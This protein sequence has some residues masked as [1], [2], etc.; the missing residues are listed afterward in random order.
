[1]VYVTWLYTEFYY[2][3]TLLTWYIDCDRHL[4]S[5]FVIDC[6]T[7]V[8]LCLHI[9]SLLF[10]III[11][12]HLLTHYMHVHFPIIFTH[13]LGRFLTILDLHVQILD[14][15]FLWSGFIETGHFARSM[16]FSLLDYRYSCSF[17]HVIPWFLLY[18]IQSPFHILIHMLSL[19]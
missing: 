13:S 9:I 3:L 17:I 19:C 18:H 5:D 14:V 6:L 12:F 2:W 10:Q 1:M 16:S 7:I 11:S 15:L 8:Y 4:T